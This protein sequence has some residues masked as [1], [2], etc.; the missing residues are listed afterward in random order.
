[1]KT[2][3]KLERKPIADLNVGD[4]VTIRYKVG[5]RGDNYVVRSVPVTKITSAAIYADNKRFSKT[6]LRGLD[7]YDNYSLLGASTQEEIAADE[8]RQAAERERIAVRERERAA[9]EAKRAELQALIEPLGGY[10]RNA[11]QGEGWMIDGLSED[12]IRRIGKVIKD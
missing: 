7:G 3:S 12:A 9:H 8:A 4:R 1:M 5:A 10:V 2:E 6:S 11:E